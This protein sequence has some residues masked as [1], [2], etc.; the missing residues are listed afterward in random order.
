MEAGGASSQPGKRDS[1]GLQLCE[2]CSDCAVR[3]GRSTRVL[4]NGREGSGLPDTREPAHYDLI[5]AELAD[6]S[7]CGHWPV[8]SSIEGDK[9]SQAALDLRI[10]Q[11]CKTECKPLGG[12]ESRGGGEKSTAGS[13]SSAVLR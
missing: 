2:K 13:H 3:R 6:G 12:Q 11:I 8:D 7:I 9:A 10:S 4:H 1:S 5:M